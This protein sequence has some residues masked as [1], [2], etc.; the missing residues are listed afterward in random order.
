MNQ[1]QFDDFYCHYD[2]NYRH[3]HARGCCSPATTFGQVH[4]KMAFIA[5]AQ[6]R[7]ECECET[8]S[9]HMYLVGL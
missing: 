5:N 9:N 6:S 4:E 8:A 7:F 2:Q 3:T 1:A